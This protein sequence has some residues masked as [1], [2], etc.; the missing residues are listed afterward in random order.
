MSRG[1]KMWETQKW[2][3]IQ[4]RLGYTDEEMKIFRDNPRNEDILSQVPRLMNKTI[5]AEGNGVA[6]LQQP[7][8]GWRQILFRQRG[9][10]SGGTFPQEDMRICVRCDRAPDLCGN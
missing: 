8:Q 2:Q 9:K 6:R 4:K 10:P 5:I 3:I 7:A 1:D